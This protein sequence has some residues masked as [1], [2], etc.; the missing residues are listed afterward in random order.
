MAEERKSTGEPEGGA[1][2]GFIKLPESGDWYVEEVPPGTGLDEWLAANPGYNPTPGGLS[3][4]EVDKLQADEAASLQ[5]LLK[6]LNDDNN[7]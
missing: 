6:A 4:E 5:E 3:Q 1:G 2:E 7:Q